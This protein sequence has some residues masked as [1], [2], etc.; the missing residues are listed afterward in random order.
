MSA[1]CLTVEGQSSVSE[2]Q[3][4]ASP[5]LTLPLSRWKSAV[6]FVIVS[7]R[8]LRRSSS[9]ETSPAV[10][11]DI[12]LGII[13]SDEADEIVTPGPTSTSNQSSS[14]LTATSPISNPITTRSDSPQSPT[15]F[16]WPQWRRLKNLG[17]WALVVTS[18][19]LVI[20][21]TLVQPTFESIHLSRESVDLAAW[22]ATKDFINNCQS[23]LV[24]NLEFSF[25]NT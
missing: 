25:M 9:T 2:S 18:L 14:S 15:T 16:R 12:P 5:G 10:C 3:Q 24:G 17:L 7:N 19:G 11:H 22:T 21:V 8:I 1:T 6:N 4:A 23:I 13:H 20:N